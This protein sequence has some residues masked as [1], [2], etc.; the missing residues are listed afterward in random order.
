[1]AASFRRIRGSVSAI[2]ELIVLFTL[3]GMP[4]WFLVLSMGCHHPAPEPLPRTVTIPTSRDPLPAPDPVA[5]LQKCL[6]R[7]DREGIRGYRL[8]LDKQERIGGTL[9]PPEVID[10]CFRADPFSVFMRWSQGARGAATALYVA[11]ENDGKMLVHP[12]GLIGDL[13]PVAAVDPHGAL[14]RDAGRYPITDFGLQKTLQRTLHDW[15]AAQEQGTLH[16]EYLGVRKVKRTGDRPC[17]VLRRTMTQPDADGVKEV[18][19]FLDE[20]TWYSV[21]TVLR[22][23]GDELIGEYLYRDIRL[24]PQ[25]SPDQFTRAAL[26]R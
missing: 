6:D 1:M 26:T 11:G 4:G 17:Y 8:V 18:M 14:A 2:L 16:A 24:N 22:G 9:E 5:F 7:Y 19:V 3:L 23:E 12:T 21:G 10:V 13:K 20:E 25:F 15:K